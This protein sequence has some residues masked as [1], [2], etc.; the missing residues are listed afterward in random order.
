M[1]NEPLSQ[2]VTRV[3]S[4]MKV[5]G[6]FST[7]TPLADSYSLPLILASEDSKAE[8]DKQT[9]SRTHRLAQTTSQG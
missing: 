5:P 7:P 6:W 2:L 3:T 1:V 9:K 4:L 8:V